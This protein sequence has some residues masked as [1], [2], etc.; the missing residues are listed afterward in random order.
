MRRL[1]KPLGALLTVA[2][3]ASLSSCSTF[4][5][6]N[7]AATVNGHELTFEQL[8]NLTNSS[9]SASVQRE[10]LSKWVQ[11]AAATQGPLD[12]SSADAISAAD[13]ALPVLLLPEGDG[14]AKATYD[15]GMTVSDIAC[16]MLFPIES[17]VDPQA[18]IASITDADSFATAAKKYSIQKDLADSG[19]MLL[20]AQG[21]NCASSASVTRN[22][23]FNAAL[24]A[25]DPKVGD[26]TLV[27]FG[28]T[29]PQAMVIVRLRPYAEL[30]PIDRAIVEHTAVSDAML[31]IVTAA[32]VYVNPRLGRWDAATA[33]VVP[34]AG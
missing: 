16:V 1:I 8:D 5:R 24:L 33:T 29:T 20:N 11:V 9:T 13:L 7:V 25:A 15:Q 31:R 10:T 21:V 17:S 19:G 23:A 26:A 12:A 27:E 32:H 18:I 22:Q 28:T 2:A 34:D 6:N 4:D 14:P 30:A 3:I